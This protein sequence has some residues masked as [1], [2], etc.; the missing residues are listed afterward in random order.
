RAAGDFE[1]AREILERF[2]ATH[3]DHI[4]ALSSLGYVAIEQ[5]RLDDAEAPLKHALQLAPDEVPVLYDYAR[6]A[7]K[8][9]DY[10]EAIARLEKVIGKLPTLTQAHYQLFLAYSRLKQTDKAQAELAEFKRLE[11]LEKQVE[12]ERILD[13]KLRTQQLLGQSPK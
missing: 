2:V 5:G 7:L 4:D 10:P 13:E 1:R 9:R 8:R 3:P 12:R 6:L 11:A